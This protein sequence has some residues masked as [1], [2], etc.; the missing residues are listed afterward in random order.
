MCSRKFFVGGNWKCN[1]TVD[2]VKKICCML[3]NGEVPCPNH[4]ETIISPPFVFIP[5]V[6]SMLRTDFQVAAQNCWKGKGGAFTGEI[7]AE[8]L[9]N[10]HVPWVILGHSERRQLCGETDAIVAEKTAYA[11]D[12]GLKVC[13]CVGETLEE[14][15]RNET[16]AVVARQ[17]AAVASKICCWA[18]VVIAYEPIW[19]IGTGKVATPQQAQEVHYN[20]RKWLDCYVSPHVA[21][22]MRIIYGGSVTAANCKEIGANPDV[23][24]FLVGG[25]S[26]KEDF[27]A[28]LN[29]RN[30]QH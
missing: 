23:D 30:Y 13:L 16:G 11:L 3:N 20:L 18:N 8:M 10:L 25:A 5:L 14:R 24:G 12:N 6:K 21:M 28:I 1:G 19:A 7:S 29:A 2:E 4:I 17:T 27:I 9:A 26:L 15:E 22:N